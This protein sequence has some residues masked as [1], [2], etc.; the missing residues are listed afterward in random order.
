MPS[1]NALPQIACCWGAFSLAA[2]WT[3]RPVIAV[4]VHLVNPLSSYAHS[5]D[6]LA[7]LVLAHPAE[8][9]LYSARRANHSVSCQG[10]IKKIFLYSAAPNQL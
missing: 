9:P 1:K 8:R 5:R 6:P 10:P 7:V 4:T 2:G 3:S